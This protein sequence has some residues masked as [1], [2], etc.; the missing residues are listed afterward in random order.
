MS[1]YHKIN[2]LY[3]RDPAT[4]NKKLL[5]GHYAHP[6]FEYLARNTW[7][8]TEK[9][10]GTN[11]RIILP[12]Y[13]EDG[14]QYG[15]SFGGKTEEAS[16]PAKLVK[17]LQERF[18]TNEA[19]A[20]LAEMFPG[21][22]VLYGEGYGPGIQAAGKNYRADQDF[23]LFDIAVPDA[24]RPGKAWW[25]ERA[26]VFD[27]SET[28]GLDIA[29]AVGCG[30]LDDMVDMVRSGYQSRWTEAGPFPAEGIVARPTCELL[31]RGGERI[32]TKLKFRDF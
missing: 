30:T 17:R 12:P 20:K 23:V 8:F 27:I 21:G 28:L 32:I 15:I 26:N 4:K 22:A 24:E 7:T 14:K 2:S 13:H 31:T 11:C 9:I 29:P 1:T 25:L 5:I 10:D 18:M 19:R 3:L 6:A 16:L